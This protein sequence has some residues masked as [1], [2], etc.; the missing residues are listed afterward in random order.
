ML[1]PDFPGNP[2]HAARPLAVPGIDQ[3]NVETLKI[4]GVSCD[5]RQPMLKCGRRDHPVGGI[6]LPAL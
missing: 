6:E 1:N 5:E 3:I 4:P 2:R